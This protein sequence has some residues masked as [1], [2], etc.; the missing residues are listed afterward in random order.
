MIVADIITLIAIGMSG[1]IA[2][3]NTTCDRAEITVYCNHHMRQGYQIT[4]ITVDC[5]CNVSNCLADCDTLAERDSHCY[6]DRNR[7][8]CIDCNRHSYTDCDSHC[9]VVMFTVIC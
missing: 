4:R 1:L 3:V 9:Y 8:C 6:I 2:F 7:H 5:T